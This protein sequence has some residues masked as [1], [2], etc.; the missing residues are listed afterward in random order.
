MIDRKT[1]D[2]GVRLM[3]HPFSGGEHQPLTIQA[4]IGPYRHNRGSDIRITFPG[5]TVASPLRL[6]DAQV[7][8]EGMHALVDEARAV[9][10]QMKA[11]VTKKKSAPR[12]RQAR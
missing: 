1:F 12:N 9:V 7:W 4:D 11:D 2:W 6:G 10:A 5:V 8:Y 3:A